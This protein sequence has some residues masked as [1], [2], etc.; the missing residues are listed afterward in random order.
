MKKGTTITSLLFAPVLVLAP[1]CGDDGGGGANT[2]TAGD[3]A[4]SGGE[5][6]VDEEVPASIT[7]D[8][9]WDCD[10][11]LPE[12]TIVTVSNGAV[13]TVSPGVTVRGKTGSALVVAQGSRLEAAG[14]KEEPIV[15][16]SSQ[17]EGSRNRGDWGGIV[18]LGNASTNLQAGVG[19]AEG[20]EEQASYG[21][22]TSV[23]AAHSCGTLKW[24]RVEFAGFE[25]TMDN[26]LNGI[27]FYSCG[28][29][30][31]V[32]YVQ[33]H[34]G[35]DDGLEMFGG[36]F[37]AKHL[38]VTGAGDDAIDS[39]QG[40]IG[41]LQYVFIQQ[42]P[43]VGNYA[44][45][46]SNQDVTQ[47]ASPRTKPVVCNVT[48]VGTGATA[49]TKSSGFKFKEGASGEVHSSIV[50]NFNKAQIDLTEGPT[51]TQAESGAIVL[52]NNIFFDNAL[53]G[54]GEL[55][56]IGEGSSFDLRAFVEDAGNTNHVDV[57]P[58]LGSIA[59]GSPDIVPATDS[60][61]LGAGVAGPGCEAAD[62][63]GAVKDAAGDWTVGW[64]NYKTN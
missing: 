49:D 64:T 7:E 6:V 2:D 26:E 28:T 23:D 14:T 10:K 61:A 32:E 63:I 48:A 30:T 38:V 59:W 31:T 34:M 58:K 55:Y 52:K 3:T 46:W 51:E 29:G 57:D 50:T 35:D 45:E 16:T 11:I 39:D 8:T 18:L 41:V 25:L 33:S 17:A 1:A 15:F 54:S 20:L 36:G 5:C 60:P 44:F 53:D 37:N 13:L 42:D 4:D 40:F 24:V 12:S 47:D 22:G 19:Q 43:N 56:T 9:T 62:Y 21:G 27:G